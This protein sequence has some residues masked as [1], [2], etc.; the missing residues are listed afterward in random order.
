MVPIICFWGSW[1]LLTYTYVVFPLLLSF[2]ARML[3][4]RQERVLSS[5]L[6]DTTPS[7]AMVVAAYNEA[8]VLQQK[9]INTWA[10]DY[11]ADKFELIIGSDGSDDGTAEI[12]DGCTDP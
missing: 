6:V 12:L 9:L 8:A 5:I 2:L 1:A 3:R 10:I 4:H 7:V 11:P